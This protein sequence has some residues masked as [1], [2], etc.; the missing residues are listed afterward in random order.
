MEWPAYPFDSATRDWDDDITVSWRESTRLTTRGF[1]IFCGL[2][3]L[4]ATIL[5]I[6][7]GSE[8]GF[9]ALIPLAFVVIGCFMVFRGDSDKTCTPDSGLIVRA[10]RFNMRLSPGQ[11]ELSDDRG[12]SWVL[13]RRDATQMV[14]HERLDSQRSRRRSRRVEAHLDLG[15]APMRLPRIDAGTIARSANG[16]SAGVADWVAAWWPRPTERIVRDSNGEEA[17]WADANTFSGLS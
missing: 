8:L 6:M 16:R 5:F 13:R 3:G 10:R 15:G 9:G 14:M 4:N 17:A 12:D 11:L 7:S 1:G 2:I